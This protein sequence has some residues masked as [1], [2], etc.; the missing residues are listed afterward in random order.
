MNKH[1]TLSIILIVTI[2]L[3]IPALGKIDLATLPSRDTVQVTIYNPVDLTLVRESRAL[4]VKKGLNQL[5]FSWENTL[6]DPTSLTMIPKANA[7]Q[8][9]ISDLTFPPRVR[10]L[11]IWNIESEISGKIPVEITYLTSGL[12][13]RAFYMGT[14]TEDEKTMRLQAYVRATNNSGE[15]YDNT[16]VR[17]IVGQVHI[18]DQIAGLAQR[19]Y[20]Y[21]RP[22]QAPQAPTSTSATYSEH[23]RAGATVNYLF[24]TLEKTPEIKKEG[25]SEYFLYTIEG[26]DS[27]MTGWSKRLKSFDVDQVPVMNLYKFEQD[28][29]GD[30]VVRFLSFKNDT[31]HKLGMFPIPG[32]LLKVYRTIDMQDHLSYTGQSNFKYI[33]V[34]EDVELNLGHVSDLVVEPTLMEMKTENFRYNRNRDLSGWDDVHTF[35]VEVRNTREIPIKVEIKRNFGTQYWTMTKTGDFGQ[36]EKEDFDTAKFTL[37]LQP[38]SKKQFEYVLRLYRGDRENDWRENLQ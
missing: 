19:Q 8:I 16:Q 20:P 28:R 4:T 32:G 12:S 27:V 2:C 6:I 1:L 22:G 30:S 9:S 38:R 29:Y 13:W 34:N 21:D 7:G 10:N 23:K 15:D 31:D 14:L 3:A 35:K 11:G 18:L 17:L 37:E 25:L 5:Q 36:F 33:P 26:K 24:S